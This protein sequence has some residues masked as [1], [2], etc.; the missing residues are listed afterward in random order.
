M[1]AINYLSLPDVKVLVVDDN[2][3]NLQ[4][5]RCLLDPYDLLVDTAVSGQEAIEKVQRK[6]YDLIFMDHLMPIMDGIEATQAIRLWEK[7]KSVE[8]PQETPRAAKQTRV[9]I[10]ALTANTMQGMRDFYLENGF[11]DYLSKPI[12]PKALDEVITKYFKG[13]EK[14]NRER[15]ASNEQRNANIEAELESRRLDMLNHFRV[16]FGSGRSID[17]EYF[18]KFIALIESLETTDKL[19]E[20]AALLAEAGRRGD[21]Q[22]IRE[23]LPTFYD[24]L[25]QET[26]RQETEDFQNPFD[27]ILSRLKTALHNGETKTAETILSELA[28]VKLDPAGRELY[29]KLYDFLV[30]N[31]TETALDAIYFWEGLKDA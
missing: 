15:K 28:Q 11:N 10:V 27:E 30:K 9:P 23:L 16:A 19:R 24:A 14:G 1:E 26:A 25:L 17:S 18:M 22:T 31:N 4:V 21:A 8:F 12:N 13:Q 29:F 7:E 5:V 20:Q 3:A 6:N 2:K